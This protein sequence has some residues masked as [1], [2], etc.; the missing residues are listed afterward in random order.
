VERLWIEGR[1]REAE[2]QRRATS[3]IAFVKAG[4]CASWKF[5]RHVVERSLVSDH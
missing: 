3:V 5:R 2:L 4:G 1:I